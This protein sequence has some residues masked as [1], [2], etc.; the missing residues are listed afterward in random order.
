MLA[1]LA[2]RVK[3]G[4]IQKN[5]NEIKFPRTALLGGTFNPVQ[6]AH[7]RLA[8]AVA[9]ALHLDFV[10]LTPCAVPPH[11]SQ[12]GLLPYPLRCALLEKAVQGHKRL[13]VSHLEAELPQPSYTW[14]LVA[15]WRQRHN[16]T[17]PLFIVGAEDFAQLE[18]W[19]KGLELAKESHFLVVP[20]GQGG[21]A[22]FQHMVR[23][24]AS[25]AQIRPFGEENRH[26][27]TALL[28]SITSETCAL[29]LPLPILD[30][31]ASLVRKKWM[32]QESIRFLT[33]DPVIEMLKA[34]AGEVKKYWEDTAESAT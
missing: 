13:C 2:K 1:L 31:S 12:H 9:E 25:D 32:H 14:N 19:Y 21:V 34:N 5:M 6:T 23:R 24:L 7:L 15:A 30:I 27:D 11:K 22:T 8:E 20:R 3:S 16:N 17:R 33:P 28:A 10:E 29:Y 4:Y 26:N 18:S